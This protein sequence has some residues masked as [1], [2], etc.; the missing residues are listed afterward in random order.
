MP[1]TEAEGWM[2]GIDQVPMVQERY[3]RPD[4]VGGLQAG[5]MEPKVIVDHVM[6][7]YYSYALE[8]MRDPT[9]GDDPDDYAS[10]H[11]SIA[12]DGRI[13]QHASIWTACM[14]AG[15]RS[16]DVTDQPISTFRQRWGTNPNQ[17]T[18][19]I[20][21]EDKAVRNPVLTEPQILASIRVHRW[22]WRMCGWLKDLPRGFWWLPDTADSRVVY[23]SQIDPRNRADDPGAN[24]PWD[25]IL[26]G[27]LAPEPKPPAVD[28]YKRG[29]RD[30]AADDRI[31]L[32]AAVDMA[33]DATKEPWD[34]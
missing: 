7:G 10:W 4:T 14:G 25:R 27:M 13:A 5:Q 19:H 21:H 29:R 9:V 31:A 6:G 8:M 20:E 22:V 23:H 1:F 30:Q 16:S 2:Q 17:F 32:H 3:A 18:V 26:E 11:F 28:E 34:A 12:Q 15:L 33:I 24:F